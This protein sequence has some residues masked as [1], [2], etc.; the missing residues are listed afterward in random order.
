MTA[1]TI[2]PGVLCAFYPKRKMIRLASDIISTSQKDQSPAAG[3]LEDLVRKYP[4][5]EAL[6]RHLITTYWPD[7]RLTSKLVQSFIQHYRLGPVLTD[8]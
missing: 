1:L 4:E 8:N 7:I 2:S 5:P 6:I 3:Q